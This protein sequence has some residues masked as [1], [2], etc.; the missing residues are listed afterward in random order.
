MKMAQ[1]GLFGITI[2]NKFRGAEADNVSTILACEEVAYSGTGAW[3]LV[4]FNNSIPKCID[5]FGSEEIKEKYLRPLCDGTAYSSL[6]F[7]EENTGSDP[8]SLIATANPDG[9]EYVVN[10]MKRFCTFG[11]R[12]GYSVLFA[13]DE[14][15][16]CTA[17]V[18]QK[19]GRGYVAKKNW[20]LMGG[21]G[22]ETVDMYFEDMRVPKGNLHGGKEKASKCY[23]TG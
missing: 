5:Q 18:I 13:K 22:I 9:D 10:G 16:R 3:W 6:Q 14:T 20:D 11:G 19:N 12:D 8:G 17:F 7:T 21:G 2:P 23:C 1:I 4:A 15:R